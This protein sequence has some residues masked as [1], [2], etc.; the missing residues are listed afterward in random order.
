M[1]YGATV[2]EPA[3]GANAM[4]EAQ[5]SAVGTSGDICWCLCVVGAARVF[6]G[7]GCS[8]TWDC[9]KNIPQNL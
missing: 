9:H 1:D 6:A 3:R 5:F 4:R 2:V 7:V 8:V